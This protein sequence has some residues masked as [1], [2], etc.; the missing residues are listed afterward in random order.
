MKR[1]NCE[2][3]CSISLISFFRISFWIQFF[4][5]SIVRQHSIGESVHFKCHTTNHAIAQFQFEIWMHN[6]VLNLRF[7]SKIITTSIKKTLFVFLFNDSIREWCANNY[8]M[9]NGAICLLLLSVVCS[10]GPVRLALI[11]EPNLESL[12]ALLKLYGGEKLTRNCW[13]ASAQRCDMELS[14]GQRLEAIMSKS[15]TTT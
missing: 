1:H 12:F 2:I 3:F 7:K 11:N 14:Y 9:F 15:N 13:E 8:S 4:F 5:L 6:M 10:I